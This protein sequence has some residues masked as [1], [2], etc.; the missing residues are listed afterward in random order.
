MHN[1]YSLEGKTILVT[2]ASSGIGV[3]TAQVLA[4]YG[5]SLIL[6]GRN[7]GKI[8][9]CMGSLQGTNHT[10]IVAD[11]ANEEGIQSLAEAIEPVN[12]IVFSAGITAHMPVQFIRQT[13]YDTIFSI[14]YRAAVLLTSKLL[15]KK[16]IKENASLVYISSVA[17]HLP[18]FGGALYSSSKAALEIYVKTLAL[19]MASKKIRANCLAP[20]FVKTPMIEQTEKTLSKETMEKFEKQHP[21]GFGEPEDVALA[22]VF[23]LSDAS[24]W[25]TGISLPMGGL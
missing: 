16:K 7:A 3:K 20:T 12:G 2:G 21:L 8:N 13:D 25:I 24:K 14:N 19:E 22:A 6:T 11:L 23:L 17:S 1:A 5:A 4:S 18:Y 9:Q 15:A 10:S